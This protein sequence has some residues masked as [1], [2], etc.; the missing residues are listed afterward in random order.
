MEIMSY[1]HWFYYVPLI[2]GTTKAL[3][4]LKIEVLSVKRNH[5]FYKSNFADFI[6]KQRTNNFLG[7]MKKTH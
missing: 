2:D 7:R 6:W 1:T 5:L 4:C 3:L